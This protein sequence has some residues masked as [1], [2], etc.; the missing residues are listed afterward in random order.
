MALTG[1]C[2]VAAGMIQE[3]TGGDLFQIITTAKYPSAYSETTDRAAEEQ[4]ADARPELA[5]HV[6]NMDAYDTIFLVYP[7]WWG[8]LPMPLFTFL[9]E[10]DFSGKTIIPLSTHE[11]SQLGRSVDDIR[12]LCPNA[13]MLDGLAIRGSSVNDAKEDVDKWIESLGLDTVAEQP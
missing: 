2:G 3:A 5:T 12:A 1:N 8:T 11:G 7:N 10:Y 9:S 6:E 13:T 4:D